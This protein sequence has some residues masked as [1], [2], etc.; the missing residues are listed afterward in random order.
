MKK[1]FLFML[2]LL[3]VMLF[4]SCG[5]ERDTPPDEQE[6]V[7]AETPEAGDDDTIEVSDAI[8]HDGIDWSEHITFTWFMIN[9][10]ANDYYTSYSDN[11]VM[12]YLEHRFN[13]TFDVQQAPVGTE[14]DHMALMMGA[15]NFTDVMHLGPFEGSIP[16]LYED[17]IIVNLADW[18]DYMPNFTYLLETNADFARAAFDDQGRILQLI[19]MNDEPGYSFS[20][21][22]YRHDILETMTDGNVQFPSG[23]D[24]PTTL[25]DWE[26]MLP[27]FVEYFQNAGFADYA[28]LII[29]AHG[30]NH[31]GALMNT[32]GAYHEMFVRNHVVYAGILEP[33]F[34]DYIYTM[35]D[36]FERGWIHQ[37]FASRT[38]DQFFMPNPP[39]VFGGAAGAF[40]GMVM[41]M[42]DRL[43]MP[44]HGMNFDIRPMSSP[45]APGIT[46]EDMLRRREDP[47]GMIGRHIAVYTGN[48]DIGRFLAI[49]DLFYSEYGGVL[50]AVGLSADQIPPNDTVMA[51]M[52]LNDGAWTL[53][54]QGNIVMHSNIDAMGGSI[55]LSAVNAVRM[56]GLYAQSILNDLRDE[57]TVRAHSAWTAQC[58]VSQVL[59]LPAQLTPTLDESARIAALAPHI[60][61]LRNQMLV[62]FITGTVP[63]NEATWAEFLDQLQDLGIEELRS[64]HQASYDRFLVRGN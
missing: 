2:L 41:H 18:L 46:H 47:F 16:Q 6:H 53:D 1:M 40:Y 21:L 45:M 64:I 60:T 9:T 10:P 39:L 54:G 20:G 4:A 49:M 58:N 50:R 7:Q 43:S 28:G 42:G 48:P 51:R 27:M 52:G 35:R 62:R 44:D 55:P 32:F 12:R 57:E 38:G 30:V 3:S 63:L 15:G 5:S 29:P 17:G 61:D 19:M 22:L 34:F 56:P 8:G 24:A 33:E 59:P 23:N 26:Y 14:A 36:W 25:A 11:P 13:V 37:D 31:F